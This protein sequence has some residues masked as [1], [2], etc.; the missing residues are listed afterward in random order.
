MLE[1]KTYKK[2]ETIDWKK[3]TYTTTKHKEKAI[4]TATIIRMETKK[5]IRTLGHPLE[6]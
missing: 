3:I 4:T 6:N 5:W 2:L 1:M